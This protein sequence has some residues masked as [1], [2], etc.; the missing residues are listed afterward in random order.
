MHKNNNLASKTGGPMEKFII[1]GGVPLNGELTPS[2]NKNAALPLLAACL[3]ASEPV[4][5]HNVPN[6]LDTQTMIKLLQ[7]LN[8]KIDQL[9][10][11]LF[12]F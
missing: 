4:T 2:G 5:L 10:P 12:S 1:N 9:N 11:I 8:V 7:S 3:L 6:I